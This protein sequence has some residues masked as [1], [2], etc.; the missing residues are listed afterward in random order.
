MEN[1]YAEKYSL[2]FIWKILAYAGL[3]LA[4]WF[5]PKASAEEIKPALNQDQQLEVIHQTW[6]MATTQYRDALKVKR[7]SVSGE[8]KN[9]ENSISAEKNREERKKL[10]AIMKKYSTER[11]DLSDRLRVISAGEVVQLSNTKNK[12]I[13][14]FTHQ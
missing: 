3:L 13:A 10:M 11:E 14:F 9:L 6:M 2:K 12:I 8:I 4:L 5:M 1:N 7:D